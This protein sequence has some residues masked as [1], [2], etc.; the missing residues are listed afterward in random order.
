MGTVVYVLIHRLAASVG[1]DLLDLAQE[2]LISEDTPVAIST[3]DL[4]VSE[5]TFVPSLACLLDIS[6]FQAA[7]VLLRNF[8]CQW[9]ERHFQVC[10]FT[11][12]VRC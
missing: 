2:L 6:I 11:D 5:G 12:T 8:W 1:T 10:L 3:N 9:Q 4:C 7:C